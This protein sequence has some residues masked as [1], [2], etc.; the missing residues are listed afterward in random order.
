[1][2]IDPAVAR[3]A[4]DYFHLHQSV[5]V[6]V[7][8]AQSFLRRADQTAQRISQKVDRVSISP[9]VNIRGDFDFRFAAKTKIGRQS[10]SLHSIH[11]QSKATE[12]GQ[13][14]RVRRQFDTDLRYHYIIHDVFTGGSEPVDLFTL[15]FLGSLG[16][17]LTDDGVIAINYAS[18]L[19]LPSA[20]LIFRT[21]HSIFPSCRLFREDKPPND[22]SATSDYANMV[23]F[24]RKKKGGFD[25]RE[26]TERDFLG[27][28]TARMALTPKYEVDLEPYLK[29]EGIVRLNESQ[30]LEKWSK[31]GAEGHWW[32]MRNS[33]PDSV[34]E[35]W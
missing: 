9:S 20:G 14:N 15:E 26:P 7:E 27:R 3:F 22:P 16:E 12:G 31:Q 19:L 4:R 2:E 23:M 28:N 35:T 30:E 33:L 29:G 1:M 17:M 13:L 8:D 25:F 11:A 10:S 6:A 34:W 5:T 32:L 18:D 24:C 21:I